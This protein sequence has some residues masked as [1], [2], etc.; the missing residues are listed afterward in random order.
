MKRLL[1]CRGYKVLLAKNEE[2]SVELLD[3][4]KSK[5]DLILINQSELSDDVLAVG[6]R[7]RKDEHVAAAAPVIVIPFEFNH[8]KEGKDESVGDG[9]YK[10]YISDWNQLENLLAKVLAV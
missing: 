8:G 6:R 10:A 4:A 2:E 1:V 5:I 3:G 7:I 9:D